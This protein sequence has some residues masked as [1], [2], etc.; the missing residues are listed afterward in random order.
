MANSL[1]EL[2]SLTR[3]ARVETDASR[4]ATP[5]P[6]RGDWEALIRQADDVAAGVSFEF[7][8]EGPLSLA[9]VELPTDV[10]DFL[11]VRVKWANGEMD[12]QNQRDALAAGWRPVPAEMV[13]AAIASDP[14]IASASMEGG[15]GRGNLVLH[16]RSKRASKAARDALRT[17]A[18]GSLDNVIAQYDAATTHG[19]L[20]SSK[21]PMAQRGLSQREY[22]RAV[23]QDDD[24]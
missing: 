9:G 24:E 15:I 20:L 14:S 11:W 22:R 12:A 2:P 18:T 6:H 23:P 10:L 5:V 8:S 21:A 1:G 19:N 17:K 16:F 3:P 4:L 13:A 7:A